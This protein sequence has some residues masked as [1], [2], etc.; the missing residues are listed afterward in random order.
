VSESRSE[1]VDV[2]KGSTE[3]L[4]L[5]RGFYYSPINILIKLSK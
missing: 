3:F 5:L 2:I 4:D 1:V